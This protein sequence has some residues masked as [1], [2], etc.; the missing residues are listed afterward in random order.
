MEDKAGL[1]PERRPQW[2]HVWEEQGFRVFIKREEWDES[3]CLKV[4]N[5]AARR[6]AGN[7]SPKF[8]QARLVQISCGKL[9]NGNR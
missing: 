6:I 8:K 4:Q 3:C 2:W 9:R 7:F 5:T 1:K